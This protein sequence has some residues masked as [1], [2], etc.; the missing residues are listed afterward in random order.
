MRAEFKYVPAKKIDRRPA[1]GK[2][3]SHCSNKQDPESNVF[4]WK[5]NYILPGLYV[6]RDSTYRLPSDLIVTQENQK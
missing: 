2:I 6:A 3:I 1:I 4:C 5:D